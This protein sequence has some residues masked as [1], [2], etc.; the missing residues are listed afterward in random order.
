VEARVRLN[1]QVFYRMWGELIETV[2]TGES[3]PQR[4]VGMPLYEYFVSEPQ[5]GA[6]FDRTMTSVARHRH[7]PAV[8]AYDFGQ[9]ATLVDVGGG[10][11]GLMTEIL[12]V[13]PQSTG[14]VFDLPRAAANAQESIDAAGLTDRC[15]FV[16]GDAFQSVPAGADA[17]ILSNF[18]VSWGD[19]QA[20]IPLRNCRDAL[21]KN[22]KVLL[23][24]W[25]MPAGT[26]PR[27]GFW[28]WD[29]TVAM[30]LNMLALFRGGS[31]RVRTLS[32][33]RDLLAAA[34]FEMI[35]VIPTSGSVSVIE[36]RPLS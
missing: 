28:A 6:L 15:R 24:E 8:D 2:R 22:G 7:R 18:V 10:D 17:Y 30:D 13:F 12:K 14:I 4:V 36:A 21:A 34:G 9:F 5:I 11:G 31:G 27:E 35:A 20:V 23:I 3:G 33:F 16:G 26:E 1:G 29:A 19:D 25:I 32:G